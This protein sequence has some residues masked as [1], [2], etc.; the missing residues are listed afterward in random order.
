M[1]NGF[2][3]VE[4][5]DLPLSDFWELRKDDSSENEGC[6]AD[7]GETAYTG[8]GYMRYVGPVLTCAAQGLPEGENHSDITQQAQG[9]REHWMVFKVDV[10]EAGLY[11]VRPRIFHEHRDGDNDFWCHVIGLDGPIK[12]E[13][14]CV[15]HN[16]V[17]PTWGPHRFEL[18]AGVNALYIS[19]RS[20]GIGIDR[21]AIYNAETESLALDPNTAPSKIN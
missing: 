7:I 8:S 20:H 9:A 2:A 12:R 16:Y 10:P 11:S 1:S 18:Q 15:T 19:G 21:I 4:A 17:W 14:D 3:I 13:A 6:E 5:E